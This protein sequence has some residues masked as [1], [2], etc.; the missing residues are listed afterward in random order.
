MRK[1]EKMKISEFFEYNNQQVLEENEN[2]LEY[3]EQIFGKSTE[4][5]REGKKEFTFGKVIGLVTDSFL[6][7]KTKRQKVSMLLCDAD[8]KLLLWNGRP[9]E[10][11]R[12]NPENRLE[13]KK[14]YI[15]GL[16][17]SGSELFTRNPQPCEEVPGA[18]MVTSFVSDLDEEIRTAEETDENILSL[19]NKLEDQGYHCNIKVLAQFLLG[20]NTNQLII[21]HGAPGMGK[22]S[23]VSNIAR[24][25][26]FAYKIIPVR[27]NWI[28]N[29]DLTGYFNPVE[30]RYYSTPFLDALCEAK[31]NPQKHYLIC[32]DEMNLAHVEY[33]FSDVLSSMES[34]E[35]IPLYAH[36]D[37]ENAWKRQEAIMAS[38]NENTV[39]WL[40]AKT[41]QENLKNRYTPEFEIPQ[42]VTFVGTLNMDATTNDLSPKVIDRSCIIKVTKDAG[43]TLCSFEQ[44][45]MTLEEMQGEDSFEKQ[46]LKALKKDVSN[47]VE[48]QRVRMRERLKSGYLKERLSD[49]DFQDM[50]L[51]MKVLPALN[52][53]E[54]ECTLDDGEF[55]IGD[56]LIE[57]GDA[58][59]EKMY[60]LTV[61]YLKQ[62]CSPEEKTMNYWRMN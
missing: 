56:F 46:L 50:Y 36:K 17:F 52:V 1:G 9:V 21:L 31:E 37:Q 32:L 54:V 14:S 45:V 43:E 38:H 47:R 61:T 19:K 6:D 25:L 35:G 40:D 12:T 29:Q 10:I 5:D 48:R 30:R 4:I 42:N 62:M 41:D 58:N 18:N 20:L 44:G 51:A 16:F 39:E 11:L 23:F 34:G 3:L 55:S 7:E 53:E 13:E 8:S 15:Q 60:P 49:R 33:Y 28:D 24:A 59:W 27:P 22:T 2:I 57:G 26:G